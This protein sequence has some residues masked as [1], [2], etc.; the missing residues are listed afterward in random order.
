[1]LEAAQRYAARQ[2]AWH[3]RLIRALRP[4]GDDVTSVGEAVRR[5]AGGLG[6]EAGG[7]GFEA[8]AELVVAAEGA[9]GATGRLGEGDGAPCLAG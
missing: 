1:V 9:R 6:V 5:A 3:G 7:R 8:L 4:H 2:A